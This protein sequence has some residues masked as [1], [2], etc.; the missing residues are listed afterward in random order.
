MITGAA[1]RAALAVIEVTGQLRSDSCQVF[2]SLVVEQTPDVLEHLIEPQVT[3]EELRHGALLVLDP[4][5]SSGLRAGPLGRL[6]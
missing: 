3:V 1:H 5:R 4:A 2:L 6:S